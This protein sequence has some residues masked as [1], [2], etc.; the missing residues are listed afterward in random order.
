MATAFENFLAIIPSIE[1]IQA[2][3]SLDAE[4]NALKADP[5]TAWALATLS[6]Q[7]MKTLEDSSKNKEWLHAELLWRPIDEIV[8]EMKREKEME[9]RLMNTPT[10]EDKARARLRD[11]H[12]AFSVMAGT[13]VDNPDPNALAM[14]LGPHNKLAEKLGEKNAINVV[15]ALAS[16]KDINMLLPMCQAFI[17]ASKLFEEPCQKYLSWETHRDILAK[18]EKKFGIF[19]KINKPEL[20]RAEAAI[21]K[22][23]ETDPLVKSM[24]LYRKMS[25]EALKKHGKTIQDQSSIAELNSH[26]ESIIEA[27]KDMVNYTIKKRDEMKKDQLSKGAGVD[28]AGETTALGKRDNTKPDFNK[29]S[30]APSKPM[31][32][33]SLLDEEDI[34]LIQKKD[35]AKKKSGAK[36]K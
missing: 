25:V 24:L 15:S 26:W 8:K 30:T 17:N 11:A 9:S 21:K 3:E 2:G 13:S 34:N 22:L 4:R 1:T 23:Q 31:G 10:R 32:K 19:T 36:P 16:N 14:L 20:E 18:G 5:V 29:G 35:A 7:R 28:K 12:A 33:G 6:A 27:N